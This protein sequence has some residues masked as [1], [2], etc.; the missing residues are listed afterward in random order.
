MPKTNDKWQRLFTQYLRAEHPLTL[1]SSPSLKAVSEADE[2]ERDFRI[3]LQHLA[4]E[5]RD[6]AVETL[7]KNMLPK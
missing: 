1:F 6:R 4:H 3:R 2:D 5:E 7:R